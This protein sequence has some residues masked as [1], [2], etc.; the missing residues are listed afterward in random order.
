M[1]APQPPPPP[2]RSQ[3]QVDLVT[4]AQEQARWP[5]RLLPRHT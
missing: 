5:F 4:Q 3:Q 2:P 1:S